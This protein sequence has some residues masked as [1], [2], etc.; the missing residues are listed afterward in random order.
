[1]SG[2]TIWARAL[3]GETSQPVF[4][5]LAHLLDADGATVRRMFTDEQGRVLF[6]T[7]EATRH[8]VSVEMLG[9]AT[10]TTELFDAQPGAIVRR[11]SSAC[12]PVRSR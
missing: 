6:G 11:E 2:Q 5:A 1:M 9:M 3:Y 12:A 7:F 10:E 4:G 8:R